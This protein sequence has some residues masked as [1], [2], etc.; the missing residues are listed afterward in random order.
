[1]R[2]KQEHIRLCP[3]IIV[4]DDDQERAVR[5]PSCKL[6]LEWAEVCHERGMLAG[7]ASG[8]KISFRWRVK[9]L[10]NLGRSE[11]ERPSANGNEDW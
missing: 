3:G 2:Q 4:M 5:E 11:L 9:P 8:K 7:I 10:E 6:K 1:M